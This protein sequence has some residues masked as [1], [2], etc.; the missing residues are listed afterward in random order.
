MSNYFE[1]NCHSI[2]AWEKAIEGRTDIEFMEV[3]THYLQV[4][5]ARGYIRN[6]NKRYRAQWIYDG[7]CY[8]NGRRVPSHD[9]A[10]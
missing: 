6:G 8:H 10:L 9:I 5:G 1:L 4:V 2:K 3:R 7:K